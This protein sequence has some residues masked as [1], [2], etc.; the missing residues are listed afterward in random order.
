MVSGVVMHNVN[1]DIE[2]TDNEVIV[3]PFTRLSDLLIKVRGDDNRVYIGA[4]AVIVSGEI[5]VMG[6]RSSISIGQGT[7]VRDASFSA[8]GEKAN[9]TL[10]KDCMLG[11][12][13]KIW[14]GDVHPI[15]ELDTGKELNLPGDI[16]LGDHV[17]L[18]S[19]VVILKGVT[20]GSG[21]VVGV[22]SLLTGSVPDNSLSVGSPAK[23]IKNRIEWQRKRKQQEIRGTEN[24]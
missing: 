5:K 3:E 14:N 11:L 7:T 24:A 10:G 2:G 21:S 9:I 1:I 22:R 8:L 16:T 6:S 20:V 13:I 4:E 12:N 18:G 23:V 17:W 15:Y 19:D